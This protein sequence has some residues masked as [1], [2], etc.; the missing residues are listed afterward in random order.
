V[1]LE[2]NRPDLR[3]IGRRRDQVV[4]EVARHE[5]PFCVIDEVLEEGAAQPLNHAADRLAVQR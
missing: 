2:R 1:V 3:K 4:G 5:L